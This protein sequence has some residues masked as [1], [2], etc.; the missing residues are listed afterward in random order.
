MWSPVF[1]MFVHYIFPYVGHDD[2]PAEENPD[3]IEVYDN[4]EDQSEFITMAIPVNSSN[5]STTRSDKF[6]DPASD[7]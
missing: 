2:E 7:M 6:S 1:L 5:T 3:E 4:D